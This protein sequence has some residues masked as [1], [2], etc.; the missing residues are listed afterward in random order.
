MQMYCIID[1]IHIEQEGWG[2]KLPEDTSFLEVASPNRNLHWAL[3]RCD[4]EDEENIDEAILT[5]SDKLEN[6]LFSSERFPPAIA[7]ARDK[8]TSLYSKNNPTK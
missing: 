7:M 2:P 3:Y 6:L 8:I 4:F 1:Q 5:V